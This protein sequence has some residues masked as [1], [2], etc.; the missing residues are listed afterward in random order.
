MKKLTM[1]VLFACV[2]VGLV[3]ADS[4]KAR[5][6][7]KAPFNDPADQAAIK[8]I[9]QEMGNAIVAAD[10]EKLNQIYADDFAMLGSSGKIITKQNILQQVESGKYKL[11]SYELGPVDVQVLGNVAVGHGAVTEKRIADGKS[12]HVELVYMDRF[13]KRT[14]K[15]VLV[16]SDSGFPK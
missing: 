5:F 10:I 9:E 16:S 15:W 6:S 12:V 4:P 2:S 11:E 7:P 14:G 3:S 8:Q 1:L 13:E